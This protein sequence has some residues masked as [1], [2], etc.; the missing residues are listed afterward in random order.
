MKK[1]KLT[2]TT[3]VLLLS[4]TTLIAEPVSNNY[5][6]VPEPVNGMEYLEENTIYPDFQRELGNDGYVVLNFHVDAVGEVSNI[7]VTRSSGT[8]FDQAAITAVQ[9]TDW[10]PAMQNG[11][12]VPVTFELP[13]EFHSK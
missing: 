5:S 11:I 4:M 12:A 3:L 2:L 1:T 7:V 10:N 13:F 8:T 9:N 6:S